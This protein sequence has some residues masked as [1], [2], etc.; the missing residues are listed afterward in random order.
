MPFKVICSCGVALLAGDDLES[1]KVACPECGGYTLLP[2][3]PDPYKLPSNAEM[4]ALEEEEIAEEETPK[5]RER[6]ATVR[7]RGG[8]AR[9]SRAQEGEMSSTNVI[10]IV[11][12]VVMVCIAIL[13]AFAYAF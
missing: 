9:G 3:I 4:I 7:K 10:L 6:A 2:S 13:V 5:P 8:V 1:F 12:L 11:V